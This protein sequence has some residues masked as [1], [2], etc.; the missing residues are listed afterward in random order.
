MGGLLSAM[1]RVSVVMNCLNAERYLREAIDSVYAQTRGDWEILLVDNG[2]SDSTPDIAKSYDRRLRCIRNEQTVQLGEAR[3]QAL[4]AARGEFVCFLDSDDRWFSDKLE[5][6]LAFF[7]EHPRIDFLHGN[8]DFI[9]A[10]G[11]RTAT[12]YRRKLPSGRVFGHVLRHCVINLQT[13]M[14]RKAALDRL[15]ELFD[16][17]LSLAEDYDLFVRIAHDT[18]FAYLHRPLAEYRVHA[19]QASAR[20]P[21]RYAGEMEYCIGKLRR[22]FA[23]VESRYAAELGYLEG[24]IAYWKA[25][26]AMARKDSAAARALLAPYRRRS[27]HFRAL[28]ALTYFGPGV[29]RGLHQLRFRG[30][31]AA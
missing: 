20:Y 6:Q 12:G 13:V 4:H 3:N 14:V 2:S 15:D 25:R 24:K 8:F 26:A 18:E 28:H 9:D 10:N 22:R 5:R 21:E 30:G 11:R 27:W 31:S 29:W 19:A 16:A 23:D 7:A 1:P 17:T